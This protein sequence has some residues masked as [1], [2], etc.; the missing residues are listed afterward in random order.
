MEKMAR[1]GKNYP[2][3]WAQFVFISVLLWML[4]LA[5]TGAAHSQQEEHQCVLSGSMY[6]Y[7][8]KPADTPLVQCEDEARPVKNMAE[9]M[10]RL[11][12]KLLRNTPIVLLCVWDLHTLF[13]L[14][15]RKKAFIAY[16]LASAYY[17]ARFLRE[18]FSQKEK[19]GK[20]KY[21]TLN[22]KIFAAA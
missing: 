14:F 19:D 20:K 15:L 9:T 6:G 8:I 5:G 1:Q 17:P 16:Y 13:W 21:L 2:V 18:L 10:R 11:P 22:R 12:E 7:W 3:Q 4:L